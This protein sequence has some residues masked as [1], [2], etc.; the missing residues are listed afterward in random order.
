MGVPL[1][2]A[3]FA[4]TLAVPA[5]APTSTGFRVPGR[6]LGP[7]R[8]VCATNLPR[9]AGLYCASPFIKPHTYDELGV[10]KLTSTGTVTTI[11]G[12]NDI[13][14]AIETNP[15]HG[16]PRP[17]LS[18]GHSWSGNG[19]HCTRATTAVRCRRGAH[20]FVLTTR[21]RVF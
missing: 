17:T 16:W 6:P 12:G 1:V 2:V 19:Y 14:L 11:P 13:L 18:P 15:D 3:V 5:A 4:L 20:G 21:L 8:I 10:L 9:R 7:P